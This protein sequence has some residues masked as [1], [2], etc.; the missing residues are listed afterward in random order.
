MGDSMIKKSLFWMLGLALFGAA[1]GDDDGDDTVDAA[2]EDDMTMP[3]GD[4]GIGPMDLP[5]LDGDVEVIVDD[6]G[7]PHIYATTIHDLMVVQGYLMSQDRFIQME[8][9]RRGVTGRLAEV[10]ASADSSVLGRDQDSRFLGF[11]RQGEAIYASLP[12]DS[13]SKLA[14]DAFVDGINLYIEEVVESDSYRAPPDLEIINLMKASGNLGRW[15]G[16]DIFALARYQAWNLSYDA[17]ADT[18]RSEALLGV[19][20]AFPAPEPGGP[21]SGAGRRGARE[22]RRDLRRLLQRGAG[23]PG[24]HP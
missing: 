5:G 17:G 1:C 22:P 4:G 11:K 15:T 6:R 21:G 3:E 10:L 13:P 9:I 19:Q 23:P 14:A 8:F 12:D 7:M 18:A 20:E 24:L 16:A 2:V